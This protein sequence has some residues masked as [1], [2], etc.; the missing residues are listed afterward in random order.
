MGYHV[1]PAVIKPGK[2]V[3]LYLNW[4]MQGLIDGD[5][6]LFLHVF[7]IPQEQ[8]RGQSNLALNSI[9]QRWSA[10]LTFV[11]TYRFWLPADSPEGAYRFELGMYHNFSME[12]LRV[13]IGGANQAYD[14]RI[15]LGKFH[16]QHHPP[17]P[18]EYPINAQFGDSIALVGGDFP[19][20]VLHPGQTLSYTLQW[21]ALDSVDGD[22]TVF[23][24][25]L[26]STGNIRA[27]QDSM[28][29]EDRYPTSMWDPGEIVMDAHTILL[30]SDLEPG[31]YTLRIGLYEPDSG[32]RLALVNEAQ[33][34]V[35]L[36]DFIM[37]EARQ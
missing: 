29:Q 20:R 11:D 19:E 22:Y 25:V 13:I 21:L 16:V 5:Y 14:D 6:Y 37:I 23:N 32:Q 10:P 17:E 1:E 2:A 30:P 24:H 34:F 3:T 12:R 26:D 35:E 7:D 18:P 33:E 36:P 8:R 4:Q 15:Y 9:I 31:K 27:Q 28:P